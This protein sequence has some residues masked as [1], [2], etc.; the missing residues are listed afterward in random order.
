MIYLIHYKRTD[1]FFSVKNQIVIGI[2]LSECFK[3]R[4]LDGLYYKYSALLLEL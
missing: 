1:K 2:K 3:L 4:G